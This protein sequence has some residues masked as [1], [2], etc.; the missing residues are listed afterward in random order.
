MTTDQNKLTLLDD[1][2]KLAKAK[3]AESA[4]AVMVKGISVS[5]AQR[6]GKLEGLERSE[7]GDLGLRVFIGKKQAVVSSS[8]YSLQALDELAERAVAMARLAPE[9]PYCGI[10][11]PKQITTGSVD[12]LEICTDWEPSEAVL[13]DWAK[14]AEEAGRAVDGVTNSEGAEASWGKTEIALAATN[15]F[16]QSYGV[17]RNSISA[18]VIAGEGVGM[19]RDYDYATSVFEKDLP[20]PEEIGRSAGEKAVRRL[21]PRKVESASVPVIFDPR[22]SA[23]ILGH[24]SGAINGNSIARGSSFLKDKMGEQLFDSS[25]TIVDDPHRKRG[26]KSKP[27]DG[28]GIANKRSNIIDQGNLTTWVLDLASARQLELETTGHAA[29]GTGG[30]PSP[31]LTNLYMEP[32]TVSPEELRA[33]IKSGFYVTELMGMGVNGVTGDYSRGAAGY[34]IENGEILFPVSELTIA[35]NLIDMFKNLTPANDLEFKYAVNAPTLRFE[36]MM[37][38]GK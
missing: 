11:D 38:A 30:P 20:S 28:E 32:G 26:L 4:D 10:A 27:F 3:G 22:V 37:V 21:N 16:A 5:V 17:S 24:L 9:D 8:D 2:L 31:S 23:G 1:L 7:G 12:D 34:W 29:R 14:R 6:L 35:S 36:E 33:D 25:I 13:T 15:G 19:E 18:S